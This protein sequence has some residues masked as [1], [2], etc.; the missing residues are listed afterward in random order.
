M[1]LSGLNKCPELSASEGSK[2]RN[3]RAF[4]GRYASFFFQHAA[5]CKKLGNSRIVSIIATFL[6]LIPHICRQNE[7]FSF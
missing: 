4:F 2:G 5:P 3:V 6:F 7:R 1:H